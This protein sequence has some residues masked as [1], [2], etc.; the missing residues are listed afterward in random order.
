MSTLEIRPLD[1][2]DDAEMTQWHA[3]S[4][5]AHD[6]GR[7]LSTHPKLAELRPRLQAE[8]T[9]E[10]FLAF[11]GVDVDGSV[12][13][14]G[15]IVLP[16]RDN[17]HLAFVDV[18]TRPD[19]QGRGHGTAMLEHLT[20]VARQHDRRTLKTEVATPYDL[21]SDGRGHRGA[22]FLY[23]HG[24]EFALGDVMRVLDLP[25]DDA[26]LEE[27][28]KEAQPHYAGYRLRH[29]VGPVPDDVIEEFGVLVGSVV[30]EAPTGG[31]EVEPEVFDADRI[32]ADE[33][34]FEAA[35]RTKYTTLALAPDGS[36]AGYT[37]I[38][39]AQHDPGRGYQWGT[40]VLPAHR[41]HRLGLGDQGARPCSGCSGSGP[42]CA[43]C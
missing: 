32:R 6:A 7:D 36:A 39:T 5:A 23:E 18:A 3:V 34:V 40:L 31:L 38:A 8:G 43:A 29:F 4:E 42:M 37:E 35:G 24:F 17:L 28:S 26:R 25:V 33:V 13:T 9:G 1:V 27:L 41:G 12:V 30:T 19:R 22:D 16:M 15:L 14:V 10:R 21:P 11:S 20:G 2:S